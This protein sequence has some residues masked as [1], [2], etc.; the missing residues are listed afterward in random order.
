MPLQAI[1]SRIYRYNH[2]QNHAFCQYFL[3]VLE[4]KVTFNAKTILKWVFLYFA[5]QSSVFGRDIR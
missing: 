3:P 5:D 1:C 4:L 2:I